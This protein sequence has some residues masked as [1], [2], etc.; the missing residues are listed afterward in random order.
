MDLESPGMGSRRG[1]TLGLRC[2]RPGL[3]ARGSS[4][5]RP[6]IAP[7]VADLPQRALRTPAR[8]PNSSF[9]LAERVCRAA[10]S[11]SPPTTSARTCRCWCPQVLA[12]DPRIEVLVVDDDSPDGTGKVADDLARARPRV[13]VLHRA[14]KQ[15]LGPAYRAG[16]RARARARRRQRGADGRRLL[17]PAG[18]APAHARRDRALR[19]GAG[20]ALPHRHHRREL[21]DRAHPAQLVR[22]LVRAQGDRAAAHRHHRRLPLRAPRG[23][24]ADR[25]RAQ[26]LERLRLPDRA[27]LPPRRHGARV[28]EIPFFFLDR[29]RGASKLTVRIGLEALWMAWWLR[30]ADLLGRV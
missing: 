1:V 19:R 13:H 29:T 20:L 8:T 22:Q 7:P 25:H 18:D 9:R 16:I 12:Q 2:A 21:A 17:A 28:V 4:K 3:G 27:Q 10:S 6:R 26:P 30:I 11:S 23:A 5:S 14:Q 15:G 24:R